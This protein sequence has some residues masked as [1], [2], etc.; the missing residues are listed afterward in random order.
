MI[1]NTTYQNKENK[2]IIRDLVGRSFSFLETFKMK[3]VG[4]K[5]MMIEQVSPHFEIYL[6]N[7][8]SINYANIELRKEGILLFL[9]KGFKN[10]TWVIPYPQLVI[11]KA[12]GI[13]IHAQG[14]FIQFKNNRMLKENKTFFD[15]L[16]DEKVKYEER[17][18]FQDI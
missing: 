9:S 16:I 14:K 17:Y 2:E 4:S 6:S 11:F 8:S 7:S 13:S 15:K 5:R 10:F 3:G 1:L 12:A 18:N